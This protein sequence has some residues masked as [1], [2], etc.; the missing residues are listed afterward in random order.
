MDGWEPVEVANQAPSIDRLSFQ[1]ADMMEDNDD[2]Q[3]AVAP[4]PR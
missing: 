3:P 1:W 2:E 4:G